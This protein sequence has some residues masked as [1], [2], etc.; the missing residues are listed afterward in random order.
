MRDIKLYTRHLCG[1]CVDAKEYLKEHGLPFV[2]ID[3]GRD[4]AANEE[5]IRLSRQHCVP[6]IVIDGH[7][8]ANFDRNQLEK[9]L[10]KLTAS[11][12]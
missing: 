12:N 3:V 6:T 2:E 8:L 1:W 7:V 4:P 10:A 5:M 11:S 9:F